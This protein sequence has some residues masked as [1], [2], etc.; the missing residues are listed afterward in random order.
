MRVKKQIQSLVASKRGSLAVGQQMLDVI[1]SDIYSAGYQENRE[2]AEGSLGRKQLMQTR[3]PPFL[4]F[5]L[6]MAQLGFLP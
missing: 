2:K 4:E 5:S 3:T 1:R 6:Q